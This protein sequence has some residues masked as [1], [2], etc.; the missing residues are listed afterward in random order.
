MASADE[1]VK[2]E[3]AK[4]QAEG[5]KEPAGTLVAADRQ[6]PDEAPQVEDIAKVARKAIVDK[7]KTGDMAIEEAAKGMVK[8]A[9]TV[10][11]ANDNADEY[12]EIAGKA[13]T[14]EMKADSAEAR[15]KERKAGNAD[16]EAFYERFRPILEFDFG[17]ITGKP[18]QRT[19]GAE[20][21]SYSKFFMVLTIIVAALP[22]LLIALVLYILKGINAI[23]GLV[24]DFTKIAQVF[25]WTGLGLLLAY[26]L[27]KIV[28]YYIEFYT[29]I[30]ILPF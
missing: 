27:L 16:N 23:V 10:K 28:A 6:I 12:A 1:I 22:W 5:G 21:R 9:A 24:R 13:L 3:L 7:V 18:K 15:S 20:T 29:G 8:A 11:A 25:I 14:H 2:Q 17:N 4:R 30:Q 26:M 19:E